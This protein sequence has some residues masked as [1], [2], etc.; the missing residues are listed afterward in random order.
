MLRWIILAVAVVGLSAAATFLVQYG[1][2]PDAEAKVAVNAATGPQPKVAVDEQLVYDFGTMSHRDEGK[3][4]W[5]IRNV[6][7]RDLEIWQEGKTSCSCTV[8]EFPA[9]AT[10]ERGASKK[11][12]TVKP[13]EFTQINLVWHTKEFAEPKYAQSATIGTTDPGRPLFTIGVKGLVHPPVV[14]VPAQ[15]SSSEPISNED[16]TKARL[17]I[18]SPDRPDT[19]ITK[20]TTSRPALITASAEPLSAEDVKLFKVKRGYKINVEL[21]PGLPLGHFTD[22]LLIETD[23]PR[24]GQLKVP[25]GGMVSGP[26]SVVPPGLRVP[27]VSSRRGFSR[28]LKLFVRGDRKTSFE[29]LHKPDQLEV[30]VEPSKTSSTP[31][32]YRL[33]ATVP[34]GTSAGPINDEIILKTD[35]PK[36]GEIK[37]P[38]SIFVSN[39]GGAG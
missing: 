9:E 36:A 13:G 27:H 28:E 4:A 21:K 10:V 16:T 23:H 5:T 6:G 37:I 29:I 18:F 15:I 24:G 33:V 38:V 14:A 1:P 17:A 7:Q 39:T 11:R 31:G 26:I 8:A 25:I 12:V 20:L 35:H 32:A 19:K 30:S 2:D 3:H 34:A 22:E